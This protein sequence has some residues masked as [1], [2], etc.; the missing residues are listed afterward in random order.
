M[1]RGQR[2]AHEPPRGRGAL[3]SGEELLR[4]RRLVVAFSHE[5]RAGTRGTK[6]HTRAEN[7]V[8]TASIVRDNI[9]TLGRAS[10]PGPVGATR[11][12]SIDPGA[13]PQTLLTVLTQN[14]SPSS[15]EDIAAA[16]R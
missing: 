12:D 16:R 14:N 9:A 5:G 15:G 3:V 6:I 1:Q 2:L 8:S 7:T 10:P 4:I 11:D 13:R